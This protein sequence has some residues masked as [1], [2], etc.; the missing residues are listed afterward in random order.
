MWAYVKFAIGAFMILG[1]LS[2]TASLLNGDLEKTAK[3]I[4]ENG[5]TTNGV[6]EKRTRHIVA[7]RYGKIA[8]GMVYYTMNYNFTAADGRKYGGEVD[9]TKEQAY[10]L[11]D[12]QQITVRY[13]DG[14]PSIN[15][16]LG[17]KEYMSEKDLEELPY[18]TM[19]FSFMLFFF[20]GLWLCY[21]NWQRI[22]PAGK[23]KPVSIPAG[24]V[25]R[26]GGGRA[27]AGFARRGV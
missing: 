4:V 13:L 2:G 5:V 20:G 27:Q 8:G 1:A 7:G 23:A 21:S 22:K 11:Q 25:V 3:H 12:G 24:R 10:A 18:G 6:I 26:A 17:F 14:Q 15:A 19:I 9:V 16:A